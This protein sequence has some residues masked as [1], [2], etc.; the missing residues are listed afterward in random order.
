MNKQ[1]ILN[2]LFLGLV[3]SDTLRQAPNKCPESNRHWCEGF[4]C[5][6]HVDC[7]NNDLMCSSNKICLRKIKVVCSKHSECNSNV[8]M[9]TKCSVSSCPAENRPRCIDYLCTT[10]ADCYNGALQ[11]AN[12]RCLRKD[13]IQCDF[14]NQCGSGYCK[15]S[16]CAPKLCPVGTQPR[17]IGHFCQ[18]DKECFSS[19]LLCTPNGRCLRKVGINCGQDS[20]CSTNWCAGGKCANI[21]K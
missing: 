20:E 17:C 18:N 4:G 13:G 10:S 6:H 7:K 8:C 3:L 1:L 19:N 21:P 12:G 9:Y 2:V 16:L 15:D 11:C 5:D 14:D